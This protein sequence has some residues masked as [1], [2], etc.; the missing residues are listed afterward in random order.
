M[1]KCV[2]CSGKMFVDRQYSSIMHLET[3]CIRCGNRKFYHPPSDT[4]E[5]QWILNQE[6]LKAKTTIASL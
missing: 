1:I 2:K 3:Y 4:T 6:R 5:G